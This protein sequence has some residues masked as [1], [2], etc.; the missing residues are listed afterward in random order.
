MKSNKDD[1]NLDEL[2]LSLL[3]R[4]HRALSQGDEARLAQ[5]VSEAPESL[6]GAFHLVEAF[7]AAQTLAVRDA[8]Q[9]DREALFRSIE[10]ELMYAEP[11]GGASGPFQVPR[12][13]LLLVASALLAGFWVFEKPEPKPSTAAFASLQSTQLHK[14]TSDLPQGVRL[15]SGEKANWK[16]ELNERTGVRRVLLEQ[17]TLLFEYA[18]NAPKDLVVQA[19]GL[20]VEV[21]GTV[22]FVEAHPDGQ[23]LGVVSGEVNFTPNDGEARRLSRDQTVTLNSKGAVYWAPLRSQE[24][25][26]VYR[27]VDVDKHEESKLGPQELERLAFE[28]LQNK[29]YERAAK[30][31]D[32]VLK[33]LPP[34]APAAAPLL[35]DL[36]RIELRHLHRPEQAQ[37]NL[38]RYLE[39]FPEDSAA[40]AVRKMLCEL[41]ACPASP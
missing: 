21:V 9:L 8:A 36:A 16:L 11:E 1:K 25:E 35:L 15:Y 13:T 27:W 31:L 39:N 20:K 19:R 18:P 30:L 6:Q 2:R 26:A 23:R 28:A 32:L 34:N 29:K 38:R 4:R 24:R 10:H 7:E 40:P 22:F 5:Q 12:W 14:V 17:G 41:G 37:S 3:H 33:K